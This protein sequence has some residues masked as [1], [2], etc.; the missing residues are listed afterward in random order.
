[1]TPPKIVP[2]GQ[3]RPRASAR[4][5]ER[6][7]GEAAERCRGAGETW[8]EPRR[9]VYELLLKAGKPTG[10]YDLIA[11]L[12]TPARPVGPPTV[13]RALDFLLRMGLAHR[14]E[15]R[16]AFVACA[17]PEVPHQAGFVTCDA[18]GRTAE[19]VSPFTQ[20][21]VAADSGFD[22]RTVILEMRGLCAECRVAS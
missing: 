6:R 16:N 12:S 7:V 1:M 5:V 13:Y 18:C 20:I 2:P 4:S 19:L 11:T 14:I 21:G 15:G 9:R 22:I 8:S 17:F 3:P 10:A